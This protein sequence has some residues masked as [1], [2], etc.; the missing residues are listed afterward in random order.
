MALTKYYYSLGADAIFSYDMKPTTN[1]AFKTFVTNYGGSFLRSHY[2]YD[3]TED[4]LYNTS[5]DAGYCGFLNESGSS[6][7]IYLVAKDN[8][9]GYSGPHMFRT[10][11]RTSVVPEFST[12]YFGAWKIGTIYRDSRATSKKFDDVVLVAGIWSLRQ[13][14][15]AGDQVTVT[16]QEYEQLSKAGNTYGGC[17]WPGCVDANISVT[18]PS[19]SSMTLGNE[20]IQA[21]GN[22]T[23]TDWISQW[24]LSARVDNYIIASSRGGSS[25]SYNG[26]LPH[27]LE[28]YFPDATTSMNMEFYGRAN[29]SWQNLTSTQLIPPMFINGNCITNVG[30]TV[31]TSVSQDTTSTTKTIK[32]DMTRVPQAVSATGIKTDSHNSIYVML[33]NNNDKIASTSVF[34]DYSFGYQGVSSAPTFALYVG[35]YNIG[36]YNP[37]SSESGNSYTEYTYNVD[38]GPLQTMPPLVEGNN[39]TLRAKLVDR[40][41][42]SAE[43]TL[44]L[45]RNSTSLAYIRFYNYI[46]PTWSVAGQRVNSS[47]TPD[48]KEGTY[49]KVTYD[50]SLSLLDLS[51]SPHTGTATPTLKI[52]NNQDTRTQSYNLSTAT[53]TSTFTL[54][55]CSIDKSYTFTAT[56]T[57]ACGNQYVTNFF[58]AS[59]TVFMDFRA[60]GSGLGIGK[61]AESAAKLSIG[62]DTEIS[63]DL[64]VSG[65]ITG[66]TITDIYDKIA[67]SG[68]GSGSVDITIPSQTVSGTTSVDDHAGYYTVSNTWYCIRYHL[69]NQSTVD[70]VIALYNYRGSGTLSVSAPFTRNSSYPSFCLPTLSPSVSFSSDTTVSIPTGSTNTKTGTVMVFF[71]TAHT[72]TPVSNGTVTVT[73]PS[74]TVTGS[75]SGGGVTMAQVQAAITAALADYPKTSVVQQMINNSMGDYITETQ[76]RQI[77]ATAQIAA[78]N[79]TYNNSKSGLVATTVQAAID[80]LA[81]T[82]TSMVD[83]NQVAF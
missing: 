8:Q 63:E 55:S 32:V 80:E 73:I 51:K 41:G 25:L 71:F 50:W 58:V 22:I 65:D 60:G 48:D 16:T 57:D 69:W 34:R 26:P 78:S 18:L 35:D 82:I 37:S 33:P 39:Y 52:I 45:T 4:S 29:L 77:I 70:F 28:T 61:R 56:L 24:S 81:I 62:W 6:I 38:Y 76:A 15:Y 7:E 9:T 68:S 67:N 20:S 53:G 75:G 47:G 44:T 5:A 12:L 1:S 11:S 54:S 64:N 14:Y 30:L 3:V 46:K 17:L 13:E 49:I 19:A 31:S 2:L 42:R 23:N 66:P 40:F 74:Q 59:G 27:T 79:V 10:G 43:Q 36:N 72:S 83:G 21:T